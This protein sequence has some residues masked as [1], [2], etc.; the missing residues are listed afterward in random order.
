V[1][2]GTDSY[3]IEDI[4]HPSRQEWNRNLPEIK[5]DAC[6]SMELSLKNG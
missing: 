3:R 5:I 6:L 2:G 1:W 4:K